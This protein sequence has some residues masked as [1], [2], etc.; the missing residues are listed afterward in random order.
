MC[1][2]LGS[3]WRFN[4]RQK[5][6]VMTK[7]NSNKRLITFT[8][9]LALSLVCSFARDINL[10]NVSYDPTRELYQDFNAAFSKHWKEKTGDAITIR[11]SHGGSGKQARAVIDGLAADVVTVAVAYDIDAIAEKAKLLP[12]DWQRR[13]SEISLPYTSTILIPYRK[14]NLN[15]TK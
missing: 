15:V 7:R 8:A 3:N 14:G 6:N 10:L 13:L 1:C 12:P 11:Q 4:P 5:E 9:A 2:S